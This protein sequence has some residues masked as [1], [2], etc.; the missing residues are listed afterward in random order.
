MV[1]FSVMALLK[2]KPEYDDGINSNNV[3]FLHEKVKEN[4]KLST[5]YLKIFIK[6]LLLN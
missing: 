1:S 6:S 5:K 4:M 2:F 3:F